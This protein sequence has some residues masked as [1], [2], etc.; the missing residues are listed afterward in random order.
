[1][2]WEMAA[3]ASSSQH[4]PQKMGSS[5]KQEIPGGQG[6]ESFGFSGEGNSVL[7]YL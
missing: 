1:M 2:T 3:I 5:E 6:L 4:V 7:R